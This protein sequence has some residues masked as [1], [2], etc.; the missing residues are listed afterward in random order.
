MRVHHVATSIL[1]GFVGCD[2]QAGHPLAEDSAGR[3]EFELIGPA[4]REIAEAGQ[5][6][7]VDED[8]L[9]VTAQVISV[10]DQV[11]RQRTPRQVADAVVTR[12]QLGEVAGTMSRQA[13]RAAGEPA[14]CLVGWIESDAGTYL[15]RSTIVPLGEEILVLDVI[16][17]M[18]RERDLQRQHALIADTLRSTG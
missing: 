17:P 14:E 4:E 8:R 3:F 12:Y 11:L 2:G 7:I 1:L 18:E 10:D 15:K 13:C 5:L 6:W 9:R 16:A